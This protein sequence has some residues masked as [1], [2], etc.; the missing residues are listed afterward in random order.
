MK[1]RPEVQKF[2]ERMEARLKLNDY[3][4]GWEEMA[5]DELI[6]RME[7]EIGELQE[8]L[9]GRCKSCHRLC[10]SGLGDYYIP[11]ESEDPRDEAADVANFAMMIADNRE[12]EHPN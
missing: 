10:D 6:D 5:D 7:G 8:A 12:K 11:E 1:L 3:K 9:F 2:A 4:G